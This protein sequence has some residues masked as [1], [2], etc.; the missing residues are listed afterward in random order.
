[1]YVNILQALECANDIDALIYR[2]TTYGRGIIDKLGYEDIKNKEKIAESSISFYL[3]KHL[4]YFDIFGD[5]DV[6]SHLHRAITL[7]LTI[8]NHVRGDQ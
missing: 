3:I 1:M 8:N 4:A 6:I 5:Q 2:L 7:S